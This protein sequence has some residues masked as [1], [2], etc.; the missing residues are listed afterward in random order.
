MK[1]TWRKPF[2]VLLIVVLLLGW[3]VLVTSLMSA[4]PVL[5][6]PLVYIAAGIA[7]LWL[8]PMRR[9]L[10]WMEIGKWRY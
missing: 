6:N 4:W 10:R 2:G 5:D 7:W 9:M 3:A 1:P 8:L